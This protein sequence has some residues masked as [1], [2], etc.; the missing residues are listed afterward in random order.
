MT[1]K[2]NPTR[3]LE[4]RLHT[5]DPADDDDMRSAAYSMAHL[6]RYLN[7]QTLN[8]TIE[9][10]ST[11]DS[12]LDGLEST[13]ARMPQMCSQ[14][15]QQ[16]ER[17]AGDER[18]EVDNIGPAVSAPVTAQMLAAELRTTAFALRDAHRLLMDAKRNSSRLKLNVPYDPDDEDEGDVPV[19][20]DF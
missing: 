11:I 10:P 6:V 4:D 13:L 17:F 1:D 8:G 5:G 16:A 12:I 18:L 20:Q 14:L 2:T 9:Y 3:W 15:A 7:H 19:G